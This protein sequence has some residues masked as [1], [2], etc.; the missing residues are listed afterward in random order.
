MIVA[1]DINGAIG[2]NNKLLWHIPEDLKYFKRITLGHVVLMGRK[3]FESIGKPLPGRKNL[4]LSS[5]EINVDGIIT[6][7][8]WDDA[9]LYVE[10]E[11]KLFIIGG[12]EIY[13]LFIDKVEF[14]HQTLV[15]AEFKDAD[16]FFPIKRLKEDFILIKNECHASN[17]KNPYDFCFRLWKKKELSF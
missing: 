1:T 13:N 9:L 14:V 15:F 12:T 16:A 5:N 4:V 17:D 6:L 8:K 3:T 11:K 10:K 2:K 7:K